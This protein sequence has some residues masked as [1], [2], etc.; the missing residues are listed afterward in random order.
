MKEEKEKVDHNCVCHYSDF[1]TNL[2][3]VWVP[4]ATVLQ[5][6]IALQYMKALQ[7]SQGLL[8]LHAPG[9]SGPEPAAVPVLPSPDP[10][11]TA[12]P[13][14]VLPAAAHPLGSGSPCSHPW[15]SQGNPI[16]LHKIITDTSQ[17]I[18]K[19]L[20][21]C[22]YINIH[23]VSYIQTLGS[24]GSVR[25]R[26]ILHEAMPWVIT[27]KLHLLMWVNQAK[28]RYD[29]SGLCTGFYSATH[30]AS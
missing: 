8:I 9:G 2:M 13:S 28:L 25:I 4:Y 29:V 27:I 5:H 17:P 10:D 24:V 20:L 21:S 14:P 11:C 22:L 7:L 16:H 15:S 26:I 18:L 30:I 23:V 19:R 12:G 6:C 1:S 3:Q